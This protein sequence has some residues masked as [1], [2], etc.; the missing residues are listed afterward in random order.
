[1]NSIVNHR[2]EIRTDSGH[3]F[4]SRTPQQFGEQIPGHSDSAQD[5]AL[6]MVFGGVQRSFEVIEH[7]EHVTE[8]FSLG[9][10]PSLDQVSRGTFAV[11]VKLGAEPQ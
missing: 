7:G 4:D 5:L 9:A 2:V 10:L 8:K 11:V 3:F 1:M 6:V